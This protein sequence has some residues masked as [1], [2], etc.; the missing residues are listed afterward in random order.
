MLNNVEEGLIIG[1]TNILNNDKRPVVFGIN[2][3]SGNSTNA[4]FGEKMLKHQEP[5]LQC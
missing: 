3:V 4:H 2:N 1:D 5:E